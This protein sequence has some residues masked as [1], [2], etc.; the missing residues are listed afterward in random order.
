LDQEGNDVPITSALEIGYGKANK[1][2]VDYGQSR[3]SSAQ[4]VV[5]A[6]HLSSP[7]HRRHDHTVEPLT[8]RPVVALVVG[9]IKIIVM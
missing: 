5:L 3:Q 2:R 1:V 9:A 8:S 7:S 4:P 6:H